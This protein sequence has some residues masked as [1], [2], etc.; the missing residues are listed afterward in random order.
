M[1]LPKS[2]P[3]CRYS[4]TVVGG[5]RVARALSSALVSA[6][7]RTVMSG[8]DA[9][10]IADAAAGCDAEWVLMDDIRPSDCV[11]I[12]VSDDAVA[13]VSSRVADMA[14]SDGMSWR[15]TVVAHTSGTVPLSKLD[16]RLPHRGVFYPLLSF[17]GRC[18]DFASAPLLI[19]GSDSSAADMLSSLA[20]ALGSRYAVM[21]SKERGMVHLAAVFANNFAVR[22][23]SLAFE[24]CS[25]YG[26]DYELLR[27]LV[28]GASLRAATA[29]VD[30]HDCQ[31][32]PASRGDVTTIERHKA[33]LAGD[34][35]LSAVYDLI[36]ESIMKTRK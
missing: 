2:S 27:P 32:G 25:S 28:A 33:M 26:I 13:E 15:D 21:G 10:K 11:I 12:A 35:H 18:D 1:S 3:T 14:S 22:M 16:A 5:G 17:T 23:Q 6:G 24:L 8:R 34:A 7:C 31:T 19:E 9:G 36:T 20:G 4:V 30:P 29:G